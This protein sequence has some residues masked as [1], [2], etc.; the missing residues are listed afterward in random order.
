MPPPPCAY[1][2]TDVFIAAPVANW[3]A[4]GLPPPPPYALTDVFRAI[5][6]ER[7]WRGGRGPGLPL[8]PL[9]LGLG[10]V[11]VVVG[12]GLGP[13]LGLP[14]EDAGFAAAEVVAFNESPWVDDG[15]EVELELE[16]TG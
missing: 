9:L 6:A 4:G 12:F 5:A 14:D 2:L 10:L 1:A 8:P 15:F 16:A 3:V 7:R 13:K 11:V